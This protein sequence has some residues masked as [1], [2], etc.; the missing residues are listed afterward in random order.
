L[1]SNNDKNE[2]EYIIDLIII[3]V[4]KKFNHH[5]FNTTISNA[6]Y[7]YIFDKNNLYIYIRIKFNRKYNM[8]YMNRPFFQYYYLHF[9]N[10]YKYMFLMKL[11]KLRDFFC[12]K[13]YIFN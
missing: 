2:D 9:L 12:I 11:Y 5:V 10:K 1:N 8:I 7:I 13:I 3:I 6:M 4:G